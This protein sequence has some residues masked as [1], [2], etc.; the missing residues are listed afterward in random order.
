YSYTVTV[1]HPDGEDFGLHSVA[2]PQWLSFELNADGSATLAGIPAVGDVGAH[3]VILK[4]TDTSGKFSEQSFAIA[5]SS[6]KVFDLEFGW[7]GLDWFGQFYVSSKT[8]IYH[9]DHG[10]LFPGEKAG[11]DEEGIWFWSESLGWHWTRE[12]IYPYLYIRRRQR[13]A[14]DLYRT[15]ELFTEFGWFF[16]QRESHY[17]RL[18]FDYEIND[19]M[20]ESRFAPVLVTP[21]INDSRGGI[22]TGAGYH[23][24]GDEVTLVAEANSGYK[25]LNWSGAIQGESPTITF[26]ITR[27]ISLT[28]NFEKLSDEEILKGV[29]D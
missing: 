7:S 23:G 21:N 13:S 15:D 11:T 8:W 29:F 18:F 24:H 17:P 10:W 14:Q 2:L 28:A 27:N 12:D 9:P 6:G 22:V 1:I 4:A 5:V 3:A 16:Y 19:W 25:F 26:T 20:A